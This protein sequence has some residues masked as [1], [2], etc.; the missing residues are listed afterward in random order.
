MS[1]TKYVNV[2]NSL[3][4]L[5]NQVS[6]K[7]YEII[8]AFINDVAAEGVGESQQQRQI[9]AFK[10]VLTKFAPQG[11]TLEDASEQELKTI[12]AALN[13]SDYAESTKAKIRASLKKFYKVQNGGND[14]PE[15]VDFFSVHNNRKKENTVSRDDIF[16]K[17]EIRSL[18]QN[19]HNTRDRA[20]TI[21]L[22]ETGSRP[23]EL[24]NCSIG[25]FTVNE[26][27]DFVFLEGLKGTPDRTNQLV[28]AGRTLREW[29]AHHPLGGEI[30]DIEDKSAPLWV[31]KEQ[32][33]CK[34]CG[35]RVSKHDGSCEYVPDRREKM[36][37]QAY[38]RRFKSACESAGIPE[39]KRRP[40]NLRHTRLTEV[41]TFM[42]YEQLNKF[43]GWVPGSGRAKVYVHLNND[44]V[45]KAIRD[46]FNVEAESSEEEQTLKC[47]FCGT[48]NQSEF[49][50]C[51]DCGRPLNLERHVE[52]QDKQ[53]VL[54]RLNE[55]EENG[56]LEKLLDL[57]ESSESS[58]RVTVKSSEL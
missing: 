53:K 58:S 7:N 45:N 31:K 39:N 34:K 54:E 28:R 32:Q 13:R 35:E 55:L 43:A 8:Q 23:G 20:F 29:I 47:G 41:A 3:K 26:K 22:Y 9:Y 12:V 30:G 46:K 16:T 57:E 24:L 56:V 19:F 6:T 4:N 48:R 36:S 1:S 27:G 44:D 33:S 52:K 42:G 17:D 2:D 37:Y 51:R 25:D 14:H 15:K 18:L 49:S 21:T 5:Q 11:F 50:E 38:R 10:T 40:Y